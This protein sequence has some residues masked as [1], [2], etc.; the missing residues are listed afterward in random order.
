MSGKDKKK[1]EKQSSEE[2]LSCGT[3]LTITGAESL[4]QRLKSLLEGEATVVIEAHEVKS[5]DTAALQLLGAFIQESGSH[6]ISVVWK[7]PSA[8][9][10]ESVYRLNMDRL[11][12]L[13]A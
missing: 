9:L 13:E 1:T 5:I 2:I 7:E 4:Y 11:L 12:M 8:V 3:S 6:G 10:R